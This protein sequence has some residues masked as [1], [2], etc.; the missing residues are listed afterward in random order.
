MQPLWGGQIF[1]IG[2]IIA[3]LVLR[4]R[5]PV[6]SAAAFGTAIIAE[7][8]SLILFILWVFA[9]VRW[10]WFSHEGA[11]ATVMFGWN[12]SIWRSLMG[13]GML[14]LLGCLIAA[15]FLFVQWFAG[16]LTSAWSRRGAR[17]WK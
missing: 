4:W 11:Y 9:I 5:G 8:V 7:F 10:H 1:L 2:P 12:P 14:A 16:R 13:L 3:L 17:G 15:A 6:R